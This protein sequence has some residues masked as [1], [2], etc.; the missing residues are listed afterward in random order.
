VRTQALDYD[1]KAASDACGV[2]CTAKEGRTIQSAAADT[3]INII[4]KRMGMGQ[5]APITAKLPMQGDFEE[6]FDYRTALTR[7]QAADEAFM[8]L[9]SHVRYRFENDPGK[10]L[11]FM[12]DPKN[13][14]EAVALGLA[15]LRQPPATPVQDEPEKEPK[16]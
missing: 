13:A 3:D 5:Q 7:I 6:I 10:L 4:V 14:K 11:E 8:Q 15:V 16:K 2:K 1:V 12:D 9:P